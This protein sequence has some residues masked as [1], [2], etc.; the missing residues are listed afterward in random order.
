MY[1]ASYLQGTVKELDNI[2][3]R[4]YLNLRHT[5]V[6]SGNTVNNQLLKHCACHTQRR[7]S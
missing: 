1:V 2:Y 4:K 3:A 6:N 7:V 5:T